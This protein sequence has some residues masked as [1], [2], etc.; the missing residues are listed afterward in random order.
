MKPK[1]KL[2]KKIATPAAMAAFEKTTNLFAEF[3][4]RHETGDWGDVCEEDAAQN[5]AAIANEGDIDKQYRIMSVYK[6]E[7]DT[8]IWIITEYDRSV[9]T[10]LLPSD[11]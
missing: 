3:L 10:I 1:F 4:N 11:Y 6:L 2:G 8:V 9:T 7:D 5:E